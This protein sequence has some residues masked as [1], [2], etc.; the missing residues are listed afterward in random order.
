L[1]FNHF[2]TEYVSRLNQE[3]FFH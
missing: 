1:N 3:S 2:P